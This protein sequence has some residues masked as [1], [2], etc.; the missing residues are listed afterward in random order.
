MTSARGIIPFDTGLININKRLNLIPFPLSST[1]EPPFYAPLAT[2]LLLQD[3][4]YPIKHVIV[5]FLSYSR[6]P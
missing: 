2:Q 4:R 5:R 6:E 1:K 3:G